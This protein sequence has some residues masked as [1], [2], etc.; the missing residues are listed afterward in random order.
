MMFQIMRNYQKSLR[1]ASRTSCEKTYFSPLTHRYGNPSQAESRISVKQQRLPSLYSTLQAFENC[2]RYVLGAQLA[3]KTS[4]RRSIWFR[5]RLQA[6][7]PSSE[8][9]SYFSS[10]R[11]FRWSLIM[12]VFS[13][14]R[15]SDE[16]RN[17]SISVSGLGGAVQAR[18]GISLGNSK[19]SSLMQ[20]AFLPFIELFLKIQ[21]SEQ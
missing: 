21:R 13:S 5:N 8:S 2:S 6:R 7:C 9:R 16:R 11:Y 19:S 3:L 12:T 4:H 10:D 18:I 20:L 1:P 15:K 14:R 17:S